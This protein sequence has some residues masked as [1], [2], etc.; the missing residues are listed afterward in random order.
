MA[1]PRFSYA[2]LKIWNV[3]C[4]GGAAHEE[5]GAG[6]DFTMVIIIVVGRMLCR[7]PND[8]DDKGM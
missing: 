8:R 1:V 2:F 7:H 6:A 3:V 5:H 4:E